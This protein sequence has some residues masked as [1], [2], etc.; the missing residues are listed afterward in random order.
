MAYINSWA[1]RKQFKSATF[2]VSEKGPETSTEQTCLWDCWCFLFLV[3]LAI[4]HTHRKPH[5][6]H[7][8]GQGETFSQFLRD[9]SAFG[10]APFL[11]ACAPGWGTGAGAAGLRCS[12]E[13][14]GPSCRKAHLLPTVKMKG[15]PWEG[16]VP[17]SAL[18]VMFL[19]RCGVVGKISLEGVFG[20]FFFFFFSTGLLSKRTRFKKTR[21]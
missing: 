2:S 16:V 1:E 3:K 12:S 14:W 8:W 4:E 20:V 21:K 5:V 6:R 13:E 10:S 18:V 9:F 17:Q 15:N 19:Q 7:I 11:M